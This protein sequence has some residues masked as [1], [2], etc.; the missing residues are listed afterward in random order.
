MSFLLIPHEVTQNEA[1]IWLGIASEPGTDPALTALKIGGADL[2]LGPWD[3]YTTRSG[4]N[5]IH[6]QYLLVGGI[7]SGSEYLLE[8]F[9][10]GQVVAQARVRTLPDVLE[11]LGGNPFT[12]LLAS[13]FCSSRS[14]SISLG[15]TYLNLQRLIRTDLKILC[16]DQVYLDDPALYFL[17]N[18]HSYE[19]LED[20]LFRN[21][22][23]TWTQMGWSEAGTF[24]GGYQQMLQNGANFFSSDDHEFWNNAP[25]WASL[26][27]DTWSR[28]GR[29][30]WWDIANKLLRVFQT[31][32]T[33][34]V[35][36][37]GDLSFL[38]LD[39]R[40]NRDEA[41]N[42]LLSDE[43][44]EALRT[45]VN[46]LDGL[47]VVVLG[48]PIFTEKSGWKGRF[49]DWSFPDYGQYEEIM[50]VLYRTEHSILVLSGDVHFGRI[51]SIQIKDN[52]Y[53]YEI[54]ASPTALVDAKVGGAWVAAPERIPVSSIPGAISLEVT[55]NYDFQF[56]KNHFLT[57]S[58]YRDGVGTRVVT[59]VVEITGNG[60]SVV[61]IEIA[62]F[63]LR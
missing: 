1:V 54:I 39:T 50:R 17:W 37:I 11:P 58:F 18:T 28:S 46:G 34:R 51:A 31:L 36:K 25:N 61:P 49:L 38:I 33:R 47:G 15:A 53:L 57:L 63:T 32:N 40:V 19:E 26:V 55:N 23:R 3:S 27:R 13:C 22:I 4:L 60:Q 7:Q 43:D 52:V 16:G 21:Y 14:E 30:N 6:Y 35:F 12:I 42:R 29:D 59:N 44:L 2:P 20:L 24:E 45:W 10:G 5:T 8:L 9:L 48:Q 56:T 62:N 41:R